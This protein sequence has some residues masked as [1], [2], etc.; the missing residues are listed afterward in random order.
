MIEMQARVVEVD[1]D[2][3]VW[4]ESIPSGSCSSCA[5]SESETESG[6][7]GAGKIGQIFT[8]KSKKYQVIDTL[9]SR[10]GDEVIIGIADGSVLRG[11]AAVYMLPLLLIF[12]GAILGSQFAP[13]PQRDLASIA[14]AACGFIIGAIWLIRFSR[15]ASSDPRFQPVILRRVRSNFFTLKEIKS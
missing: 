13:A 9:G 3:S 14:G 8:L 7:C 1:N 10:T 15:R 5:S 6:G 11:S 4:V 12:I 2:G